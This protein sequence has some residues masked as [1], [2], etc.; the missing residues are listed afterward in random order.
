MYGVTT[1]KLQEE[2]QDGIAILFRNASI[3]HHADEDNFQR[4]E[5]KGK[6]DE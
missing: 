1:G 3:L 6:N 5:N 2:N 4:K